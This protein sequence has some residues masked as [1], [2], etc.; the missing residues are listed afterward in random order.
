MLQNLGGE[1]RV[2]RGDNSFDAVLAAEVLEHIC[3]ADVPRA[4]QEIRRVSKRF[5][6]LGLPHAGFVFSL[7]FKFP[8]LPRFEYIWK[9]PF[10]WKKHRFQGEHYWELGKRDYGVSRLKKLFKTNGFTV[11]GARLRADDPAHYF[12]IL[13]KIL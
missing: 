5:V 10:F 12:F 1:H 6:L 4:L 3:F 13:E 2:K 8:L 11:R 9:L 7:G